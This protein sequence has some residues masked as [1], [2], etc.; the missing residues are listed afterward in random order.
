MRGRALGPGVL[1]RGAVILEGT[2]GRGEEGQKRKAEKQG[3]REEQALFDHEGPLEIGEV[4]INQVIALVD[5]WI[6]EVK[7]CRM[8]EQ[9]R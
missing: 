1:R 7:E 6:R 4:G 2:N 3:G 9:E 8:E 5:S